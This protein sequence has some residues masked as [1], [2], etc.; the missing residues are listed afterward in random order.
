MADDETSIKVSKAARERLGRLAQENGT[1]IRGLVE[2]LAA[3]RLTRTELHERG[4]RA[5]A[6][7]REHMGV[8]LTDADEEPGRRLLDAITARSGGSHGAAA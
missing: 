7:L 4:E 5:R 8:E 1:T 6:Y 2:E 3:A